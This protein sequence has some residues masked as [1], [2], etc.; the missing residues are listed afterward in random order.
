MAIY[1]FVRF[2]LHVICFACDWAEKQAISSQPIM[3]KADEVSLPL[4]LGFPRFAS[5]LRPNLIDSILN[6]ATSPF[7]FTYS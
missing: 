2:A 1:V 7:F 6:T 4:V 3:G 5:G